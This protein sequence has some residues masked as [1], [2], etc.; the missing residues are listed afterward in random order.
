MYVLKNLY[1]KLGKKLIKKIFDLGTTDIKIYF[2]L[3]FFYIRILTCGLNNC[4]K[5]DFN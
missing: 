1:L 2:F 3:N 5:F 4:N